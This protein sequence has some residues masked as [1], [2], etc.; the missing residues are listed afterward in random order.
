MDKK[1]GVYICSGCEIGESLDI[2]ALAGLAS[3]EYKVPVCKNHP[4]LCG[5]EGSSLIRADIEKEGVTTVVIAACSPRE[6]TD[7]FSYDP[8]A[9]SMER[10]NLREHVVWCHPPNDE[11]T[12]MLAEDY[13]RMGIARAQK[14]A[15]L[16]PFS[17]E[18][19]KTVLVVGGGIT[20]ITSALDAARAGK[21]VV[22]VEKG[23]EL[24]GWMAKLWKQ[25]PKTPPYLELQETGIDSKIKEVKSNTKIKIYTGAN[26]EKTEGAPGLFDVTISYDG[27]SE[28]VR[29]GAIVE[30]TGWQPYDA[31]K[32]GHLGFGKSPD[33]VTNIMIEEMAKKGKFVRPSDGKEAKSVAFIQCAGS[34]DSNH[35]PYC[36]TY[37]CL[38][39]LKQAAYIREQDSDTKVYILYK[40]MRTPAQFELFYKKV[41]EDAGIFLTKGEVVGV[42]E[43][44]DKSLIIDVDNTLLG[45]SIQIKADMVVLATGMVPSAGI[46]V[47]DLPLEEPEGT[48]DEKKKEEEVPKDF[49]IP[50]DILNLKYRQ[51]PELPSL[52]YGFP[53]S[54]Y[55]CFPYETRRTGIYAAGCVRQPMD[56]AACTD[57]AAGAVLKAIQCVELTAQGKAVHPRAG[58]MSYPELYLS[59][60]TQCKRCTEECPFGMYNED[61][62]GNPLPNPTRCRRCGICMGSCPE[63]IIS[64]KDY[65]VDIIGSMVKAIDVPEEDEEKPRVVAFLCENDAYPSLDIVGRKR[66][67]YS[68]YVRVI[69]L[70]CLGNVN[71][72]WIADALSSGIDGVI[73]IGCKHGDD[74]QCHYIKGSELASIRMGKIKETL[75]RLRLESDRVRI[76][77]LSIDEYAQLPGIFDDFME[78]IDKVGPNPYKDM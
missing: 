54:H 20:G 63:R 49:I 34:R 26:I 71:L 50:S 72:V 2:E 59:R 51:G 39:S 13:M 19:D 42:S 46:Q 45:D 12:Q 52:K 67:T 70:R 33:V 61:E 77:E 7:V 35:L 5:E 40:D 65:S 78:T 75:D 69:P 64:F 28:T 22:L 29:V 30:A 6:K 27:K 3:S 32:L 31:K 47:K 68:P 18:I 24:G 1:I 48:T 60:C 53:D 16:E 11:D 74:Y 57:D 56:G 66:M 62:K 37:C 73:L 76:L 55:I 17:E 44:S 10:I 14:M 25:Y 8:T 23:A 9:I 21:D 38:T 41:Q 15:P 58:D 36:S 4:M 43:D